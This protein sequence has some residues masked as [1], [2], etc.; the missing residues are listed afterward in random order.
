MD[1]KET[2]NAWAEIDLNAVEHNFNRVKSICKNQ[3]ICCVIKADAYGHGAVVLAKFYERLGVKWFA[4]ANICEALELRNNGIKSSILI[5]GYTKPQCAKVLYDDNLIQTVYSLEYAK[6][7]SSFALKNKVKVSTHIKID[8]GMARLGFRAMSEEDNFN[9]LKQV[10]SLNG[11][12]IKGIYTHLSV[13]DEG[14]LGETYTRLQI[15][16]FNKVKEFLANNNLEVGVAHCLNSAGI[17]D[18]SQNPYNMV[19]AGISLYGYN[20]S[21]K[22]INKQNFIPAMSLKA[23]LTQIKKINKGD[24]VGYGRE[25]VA[26]KKTKIAIVSI[27]YADGYF[28]NNRHSKVIVGDKFAKI[29]GR[30]CMDQLMIDVSDMPVQEGD[31]VE[32][33]GKN[34]LLT[35]EVVAKNT[36]TICY[37]VLTA[38]SRRVPRVYKYNKKTVFIQDYLN[39][40]KDKKEE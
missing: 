1:I 22:V 14:E 15:N 27:G 16:R 40:K 11:L 4:V 24:S 28:R 18:Y 20:P 31:S 29:I 38:V 21:K 30:I 25:F 9:H 39:P 3:E 23:P 33:F 35:A 8:T 7:L 19:R 34:P 32:L 26:T 37:E 10:F 17:L 5:L 13:A 2:Y 6:E 12:I 36:G